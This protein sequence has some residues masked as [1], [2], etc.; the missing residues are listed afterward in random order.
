METTENIPTL[1]DLALQ[2]GTIGKDQYQHLKSL[3][4][5]KEKEKKP[6]DYADLILGQKMATQYQLGLLRLIQEYHIIRRRGEEFGKIAIEKGF[7][8]P[9]DISRALEIQKK[10]FKKSRLRKLIGDIL[11]ET[12]VITTKQKEKILK[13]Q[14]LFDKKSDEILT[15]AARESKDPDSG[16]DLSDYEKDFL[17]IKALDEEFSASVIE[18]GLA[19]QREVKKAKQVQ[20]EEFKS[21]KTINILGDIMVSMSFI[22]EEQKN[23]IL[24]EQGRSDEISNRKDLILAVS[25]SKDAMIAWIQIEN[26]ENQEVLLDQVK[27]TISREGIIQGIYPDALIQ[28]HL[29]AGMTTFPVA[30]ND[31]S[32]ALRSVK[33]LT[34]FFDEDLTERGEKRKGDVLI[35]ED[36]TNESQVPQKSLYGKRTAKVSNLDFTIRCASGTRFSRDKSKIIASKTGVPA[37]SV[38]RNLYIHPVINV[39]EDADQRYGPLEPYSNIAVS[40]IITGAY[41]ITAGSIKAN[42]IRGANIEAIGDIRTDVGITDATIRAQGDIHARYLHNC[43]VETFGDI[44]IKNEIIDSEIRCSGKLDSPGCRVIT[45]QIFAK[46]GVTLAGTGSEKTLPCAITAGGEHHIIGLEQTILDEIKI[47][48]S[49]LEDLKTEKRE[50]RQDAKRT[51]QKMVELK[52]F[53]DRAKQKKEIL[54]FEFK[55]KKDDHSKKKLKN[56]LKLI[57]TFDKRMSSSVQTL[58]ELNAAKK[59]HEATAGKL[60]T[61]I[62]ALEAKTKKEVLLLEQSLF[63]YLEW[64]R[65]QGNNPVI[66][67]RGKAFAGSEF[68]GAYSNLKIDSDRMNFRI[69]EVCE[70]DKKPA[71]EINTLK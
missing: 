47:I 22:T 63:A 59:K 31:G 26:P 42:E 24:E 48:T 41:P 16:V 64:T 68:N 13:E 34:T 39:L 69:E 54:S 66:E 67:I 65:T 7:A 58:K 30:R 61:K 29:D 49:K 1:A 8:T 53:H 20:E 46:Q 5:L 55:K 14:T 32:Q 52:I 11:V 28:A 23:I 71:L 17:R 44:Y 37:L 33:K 40:G 21:D 27:A 50:L 36:T 2:Y 15:D 51:F 35:Q 56:I 6:A 19:S 3:F 38:E 10:E 43:R 12:R 70:T 9:V 57:S 62:K 25:V 18:K 4:T 45:S 60:T